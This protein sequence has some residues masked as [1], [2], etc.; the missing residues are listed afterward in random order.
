VKNLPQLLLALAGLLLAGC[1]TTYQV[2]VSALANP[3]LAAAH[4]H[5][6][7]INGKPAAKDRMPGDLQFQ[8][9]LRHVQH[10][11]AP[12]GLQQADTP[13]DADLN[14]FVD[15][16]VGD[17]VT[18]TYTFSTP[19]YAELGGGYRTRSTTSKDANG[20]TV[21]KTESVIVPGRYE[22]V[23]TDVTVNSITTY[24]KYLRL[25]ARQRQ[26]GVAADQGREVWTVT[27][28][29]DDQ[30]ADLRAALPLLAEAITPYVGRDTGRAI[31]VEFQV[32]DGRLVRVD[33][34]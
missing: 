12:N 24:R 34:D 29:V 10:A 16:G 11:L 9:V 31:V 30:R 8:E 23:G 27:A 19:V 22:R 25:S 21:T 7:F 26:P 15:F 17:P 2:E 5:Y 33:A 20:K 28:I 18:R 14:I 3:Q 32:K 6:V 4:H 1:T 13:A